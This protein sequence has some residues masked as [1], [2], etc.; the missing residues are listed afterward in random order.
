MAG[1][2]RMD[3]DGKNREVYATGIMQF[4]WHGLQPCRQDPVVHRQPGRRHGRRSASGR[5]QP[6]HSAAGQDFGFPYYGGGTV[7]TVEYKDDPISGRRRAATGRDSP[8]AADLGMMFYTGR[9]FPR[10][11]KAASLL[12]SMGPGTGPSRL[13]RG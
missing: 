12:L 10:S 8:H 9:M 11:T 6:H 1:I 2:I 13:G 4:G 5:T 3:Q 7:R